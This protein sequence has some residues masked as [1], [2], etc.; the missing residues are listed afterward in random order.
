MEN[1]EVLSSKDAIV[2]KLS[3][4]WFLVSIYLVHL[5]SDKT[6]LGGNIYSV[7]YHIGQFSIHNIKSITI[8]EKYKIDL[9]TMDTKSQL[10]YDFYRIAKES[11]LSNIL[12]N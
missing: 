1:G 6:S 4:G 2:Q 12:P 9:S 8:K 7:K 11:G 10:C 3:S 5:Q